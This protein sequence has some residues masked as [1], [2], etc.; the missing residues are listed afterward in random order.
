MFIRLGPNKKEVP[1]A[2]LVPN[3]VTTLALCSGLASLHFI[4]AERWTHALAAMFAAAVF[5]VLDGG[6]ARLLRVSSKFGAV[7][8]SLSDFLA[9]GVAPAML[10]H[11]WILLPKTTKAIDTFSLVAIMVYAVCA[12][13]R[14]ARFTSA[15]GPPVQLVNKLVAKPKNRVFF[16]GMPTP[17]AGGAVL[18]PAYLHAS[19]LGGDMLKFDLAK[20]PEWAIAIYTLVIALLM[21]SR[22]PMFAVKG[23]KISRRSV[24]PVMVVLAVVAVLLLKETWL[25]LAGLSIAYVATAPIAMW[26]Q[27]KQKKETAVTS[28]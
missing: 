6:A 16:V 15:I 20:I 24:A 22:V 2:V 25:T 13:L 23:L 5:D 7:L 10:L 17:A 8:D 9:F 19:Q 12:A 14:L 18:V 11:Q 28:A 21:V 1:I 26:M 27:A 3:M 4:L